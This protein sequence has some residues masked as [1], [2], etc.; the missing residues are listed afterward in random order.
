MRAGLYRFEIPLR[1]MSKDI[2]KILEGYK[3][4]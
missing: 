1:I 2:L 4:N 3:D